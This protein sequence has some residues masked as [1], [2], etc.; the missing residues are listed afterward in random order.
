MYLFPFKKFTKET[1]KNYDQIRRI[2]EKICVLPTQKL[3]IE[4]FINYRVLEY[5]IATD[6]FMILM[7][8]YGLSYGITNLA[9]VLNG[10]FVRGDSGKNRISFTVRPKWSGVLTLA[11]LYGVA[12]FGLIV[13]IKRNQWE[14]IVTT[15]VFIAI[16]YWALLSKFNKEMKH[17]D[18]VVKALSE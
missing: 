4:K 15:A 3:D 2:L 5:E 1:S 13:S 16:T 9:P 10:K 6:H 11:L 12:I 8:R 7:G 14:G 17:Y 18:E